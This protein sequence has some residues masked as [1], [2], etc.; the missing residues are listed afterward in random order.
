MNILILEDEV[1]I[2]RLLKRLCLDLSLVNTV[3]TAFDVPSALEKFSSGIF[4]LILVDLSLGD[5]A[6]TGLDFCEQVRTRDPLVPII[7]LTSM[8]SL[9][10]IEKAF[11]LGVNDYVTKPFHPKELQFRIQRWCGARQTTPVVELQYHQLRFDARANEF[12]IGTQHLPLSKKNKSLL[13]LFL[14]EAEKL[15]GPL[16]LKEK[17]W[18]DY[19][20]RQRNLRSS[21]QS[22]RMALGDHAHWIKT[23]RGEGYIL[24]KDEE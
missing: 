12:Y 16:Y 23:V 11:C 7:V 3:H 6:M 8:Y 5:H 4:D 1:F 22:L 20:D 24:K 21:I 18:G 13:F 2:A 17:F 10:F 15:L 14:K 19:S 9:D